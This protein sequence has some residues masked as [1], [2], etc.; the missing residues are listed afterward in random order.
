M[1]PNILVFLSCWLLACEN[2]QNGGQQPNYGVELAAAQLVTLAIDSTTSLQANTE[3]YYDQK[4]A[5]GYFVCRDNQAKKLSFYDETTL[6]RSF[7]A[8]FVAEGPDG[9]GEMCDFFVHNLDSIFF[10][11]PP[12]RFVLA[13]TSGRVKK[14][15]DLRNSNLKGETILAYCTICNINS[16]PVKDDMFHFFRWPDGFAS[17]PQVRRQPFLASINLRSGDL[18]LYPAF[19]PEL[20][21]Q[22]SWS[23]IHMEAGITRAPSGFVFNFPASDSVYAW[24]DGKTMA[25]YAASRFITDPLEPVEREPTT[26]KE[27]DR[28]I[29][30]QQC[31]SNLGYDLWRQV[32]YRIAWHPHDDMSNVGNILRIYAEK[33]CSIIILNKD[34]KIIGET[35]LP[36]DRYFTM[37]WFIGPQGLYLSNAHPD[38]PDLNEDVLSYTLFKL[39]AK[40]Q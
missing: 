15:Y 2:E 7:V 17:S 22:N 1:K 18:K 13:D 10:T 8:R 21:Q 32:Y 28:P 33:P 19:Y 20:Y 11:N 24:Q 3:Y 16:S 26:E 25:H 31:Y 23:I 30:E 36:P 29:I 37:R 14:V 12:F 6:Q 38:N 27:I 40:A 39:E 4:S 35:M 34:L 9:I 5:K